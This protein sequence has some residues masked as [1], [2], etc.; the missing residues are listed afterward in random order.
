MNFGSA[1]KPQALARLLLLVTVLIWGASFVIVKAAM[2]DASPLLFNL[3]RMT[4]AALVLAAI[5][6]REL[7]GVRK[8]Q[9]GAGALA[10]LFLALGYQFQTFGLTRT[11]AAKSAFITG[12]I[13]VFVPV[14]TLVPRFRARGMRAPGWNA[15]VG[16]VLAFGGLLLITTP[17][18]TRAADVFSSIGVGDLLTLVCALAF[19]GHLLTLARVSGGIPAGLLAALQI[20]GSAAVMLVTLPLE[21][22]HFLHFTGRLVVAFGVTS[23][24]ATAAAFTIQSYAQQHL[25]A[26]QTAVI[27]TLEPVFAGLTSMI[28]LHERLGVRALIG[29]GLILV[30]IMVIE[31]VP[32]ATH[33][34]EIP[35]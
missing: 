21:P 22:V 15:G 33:V 11:T 14:L 13:V 10:G 34:T 1:V 30:A 7:W 3:I 9:L 25:P 2:E 5:N 17:A 23:L 32:A 16:A 6:W 20:G 19:A 31:L 18:G 35:A 26:T 28:F 24:L 27:L 8:A 12:L 4:L 29:A